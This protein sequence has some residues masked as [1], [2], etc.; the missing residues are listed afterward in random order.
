MFFA[1]PLSIFLCLYRFHYS[2]KEKLFISFV[3]LRGATS[4]LL[5]LAPLVADIPAAQEIFSIIFL[6][7]LMSLTLQGLLIIP[8]DKA[9]LTKVRKLVS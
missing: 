6:M 8:V 3:G 2:F 1:R 4:V 9:L 7:V 5:A